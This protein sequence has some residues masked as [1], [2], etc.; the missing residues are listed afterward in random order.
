MKIF[1]GIR[2]PLVLLMSLIFCVTSSGCNTD[3][4]TMLQ[5]YNGCYEKKTVEKEVPGA[6]SKDF[7]QR[8]MIRSAYEIN[9]K[10][11]ITIVAPPG[12]DSYKWEIEGED[13]IYYGQTLRYKP[14][15][16][17]SAGISHEVTLT[18]VYN[19]DNYYDQHYICKSAFKI[20]D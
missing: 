14:S 16:K 8:K 11:G 19:P 17:I 3:Y 15:N 7:D 5:E 4:N 18:V 1:D 20:Y 12:F 9:R 10:R 13:V 2:N 6:G